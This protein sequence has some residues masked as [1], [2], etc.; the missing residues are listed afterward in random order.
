[1]KHFDHPTAGYDI[2]G[3]IH[4]Q[5]DALAA[6]LEELGYGRTPGGH[7]HPDGRTVIFL[8]DYIDRGPMI[9][10]VLETVRGMVEGGSALAIL[11]NHEIN[12]LRFHTIGRSGRP[13]RSHSEAHRE[14]HRATVEQFAGRDDEWQDW[15]HWLARLPLFLELP[16]LRAVHAS[17][18]D[19]AIARLR[20]LGPLEGDVLESLSIR[21]TADNELLS[22]IINGPEGQLPEGFFHRTAD[23]VLRKDFRVKWWWDLSLS[24]CRDAVF[25]DDDAIPDVFPAAIPRTGY[26]HNAPATF[27][28]HYA[29]KDR[30]PAPIQPNLA[31]L[32]YGAGKGGF[33]CAYRWD[34]EATLAAEK[35]VIAPS[36]G[37]GAG[38][39]GAALTRGFRVFVDD[40]FHYMD[41]DERWVLGDFVRYEDALAAARHLVEAF[42]DEAK[43]GQ[44]AADLYDDYVAFGDDPFIVPIGGAE[45]PAS[46]FSAWE[47]ARHVAGECEKSFAETPPMSLPVRQDSPMDNRLAD[48]AQPPQPKEGNR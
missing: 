9:R 48:S 30:N 23:G 15:L 40:N 19:T 28:G 8:G 18:D 3:D 2:I 34:G 33:L 16:G 38:R 6:L 13:L 7:A 44:T 35:F 29:L 45:L 17:W 21:G 10:E 1:M 4:G 46:R 11:G 36:S 31:C 43:P 5:A 37:G 27:F 42:F 26:S 32:D 22:R 24:T 25:P 39:G 12:A 41:E 14:Q 47:Y 20:N